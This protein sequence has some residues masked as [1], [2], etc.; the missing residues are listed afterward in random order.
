MLTTGTKYT[1]NT[2]TFLAKKFEFGFVGFDLRKFEFVY[3]LMRSML[4]DYK[5]FL[6]ALWHVS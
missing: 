2:S 5:A 6:N 3:I 1:K 4:D